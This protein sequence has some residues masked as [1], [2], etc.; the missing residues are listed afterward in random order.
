MKM[1]WVQFTGSP[2]VMLPCT[3]SGNVAVIISWSVPGVIRSGV[4]E[5]I[6]VIA[7]IDSA[8]V[9]FEN[10]RDVL[11]TDWPGTADEMEILKQIKIKIVRYNIT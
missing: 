10:M 6:G 3:G 11:S 5:G 8:I 9:E 4:V 7:E 2:I 1:D